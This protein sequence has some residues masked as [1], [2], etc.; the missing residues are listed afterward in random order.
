MKLSAERLI[1]GMFNKLEYD[2]YGWWLAETGVGDG[3]TPPSFEE[4]WDKLEK[5]FGDE[6]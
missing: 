1:L 2:G 3:E 5:R 4:F 6:I